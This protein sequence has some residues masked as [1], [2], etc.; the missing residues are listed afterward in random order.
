MLANAAEPHD[1]C[2]DWFLRNKVN[3]D[4]SCELDCSV[5]NTDMKTYMC[6]NQCEMLCKFDFKKLEAA[7]NLY[8]LT[9]DEV[10]ICKSDPIFCAQVYK[11]SL[12]ADNLCREIYVKSKTNDESDA[13]RHFMWAGIMTQSHGALKA[14]GVLDAHE[15][16]PKEPLDQKAM[17]LANNRAG[18]FAAEQLVK[19]KNFTAHELKKEFLKQLKEGSLI[20]IKPGTK[21][22][23]GFP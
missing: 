4:K 5:L 20:V 13:C 18:I 8:G 15:N 1:T 3:Q 23:M 7:T 11:Q 2:I 14:K 10:K 21:A 9:D 17:D 19:N 6:P 16:N 12:E 22:E